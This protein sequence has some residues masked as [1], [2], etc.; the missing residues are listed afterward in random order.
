MELEEIGWEEV[1]WT[2]LAEDRDQRQDFV[3]MVIN[4]RVGIS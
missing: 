2:D 3:N 4:L 1:D